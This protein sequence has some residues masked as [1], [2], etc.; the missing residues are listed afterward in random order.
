MYFTEFYL[1]Y[2]TAMFAVISRC[3]AHSYI[4]ISI[5]TAEDALK[6]DTWLSSDSDGDDIVEFHCVPTMMFT[7]STLLRFSDFTWVRANIKG[8]R[9]PAAGWRY[10]EGE[11]LL[12]PRPSVPTTRSCE[13]VLV[14]APSYRCTGFTRLLTPVLVREQGP[15]HPRTIRIIGDMFLVAQLRRQRRTRLIHVTLNEWEPRYE[16]GGARGHQ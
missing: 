13:V 3:V 11:R 6:A 14:T 16:D 15:S 9:V 12:P 1:Q 2:F 7:M 10:G 8:T 5:I 4:F